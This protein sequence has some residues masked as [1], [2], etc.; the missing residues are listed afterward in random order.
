M[1]DLEWNT[2]CWDGS[3]SWKGGGEEWSEVWGGSEAQW[4]GSLYPRLHRYLPGDAVLEIAPGF[5]RWTKFLLP[6]CR[7]YLGI[8]LSNE[9]VIA[10]RN[11]FRNAAHARF[12][13]NDGLTLSGAPDGH[14]SFVFSFDSLVHVETEVIASYI[15]QIVRKLTASGVAFL[16]HSN[17]AALRP[18]V[19]N[20]HF[21]A[22][23]VSAEVVAAITRQAG[24]KILLQER[25]NWGGGAPH[26]TDCLTVFARRE[27]PSTAAPIDID[28]PRFMI[29]ASIIH[30]VHARYAG[31]E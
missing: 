27:Y 1:P 24:G 12:L 7:A 25:L 16:H 21:R 23:S 6:A 29:E 3:Y 28:N 22:A 4:F 19:E 10:C 20:P 30:D 26:L 13:Q 14:F 17:L 15:P 2:V 11:A 31:A 8:D 5:G 18:D 9:C